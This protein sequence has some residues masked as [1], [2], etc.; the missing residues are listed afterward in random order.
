MSFGTPSN[1]ILD[2]WLKCPSLFQAILKTHLLLSNLWN[3]NLVIDFNYHPGAFSFGRTFLFF[4]LTSQFIYPKA[5][6]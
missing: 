1:T 2:G 5:L 3:L 6:L 4:L